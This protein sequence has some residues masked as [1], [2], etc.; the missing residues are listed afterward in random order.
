M[1]DNYRKQLPN[2][3]TLSRI[4]F[5]PF[6]IYFM[7]DTDFFSGF[8]AA[9]LFIIASITDYYDGYFARKYK[10]E[11]FLGKFLDPISDKL[12][13]S[14]IL[15][16][17]VYMG[18]LHPVIVILLLS[19]DTLI[20][21]LRSVAAAENVVIAAGSMGKWKTALQMVTIPAMQ[22]YETTYGI[23]F[24]KIGLAGIYISLALSLVSGWQYMRDFFAARK[25]YL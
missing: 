10:T 20:N 6:I 4:A 11:S 19:R 13:V 12:L 23:P 16:M 8:I 21:G 18:R 7:M 2:M 17:F 22:I 9:V 15:I 3:I 1:S 24:Y 25:S 14:S 5:V